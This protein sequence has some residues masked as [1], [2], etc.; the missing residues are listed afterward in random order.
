MRLPPIPPWVPLLIV[1]ALGYPWLIN[2]ALDR[3][4][5]RH[6]A[7]VSL[8]LGLCSLAL[9]R[10]RAPE[11]HRASRAVVSQSCGLL[12]IAVSVVVDDR[13]VL[14]LIPA[15]VQA[16]LGLM[17]WQSLREEASIVERVAKVMQPYVPPW[18]DS[19]CRLVTRVWA[20]FFF[21]NTFVVIALAAF[22]SHDSWVRYTGGGLYALA[23]LIQMIEAFVRKVWFRAFEDNFIDRGFR[24]VFPPEH[25]ERGR[26]S[27]AFIREM[28]IELGMDP[29]PD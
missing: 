9:A 28:R 25:T 1:F 20:S 14:Y 26:R 4:G 29:A 12:L 2:L 18:I 10:R 23:A 16:S 7:L 8:A 27:M 11:S 6:V 21:A 3:F 15:V 24:Y 19:Y 17:F 5:A 22:G 13:R